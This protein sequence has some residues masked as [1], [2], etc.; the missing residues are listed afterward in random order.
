[1]DSKVFAPSVK[2]LFILDEDG[3]RIFAQYW[4]GDCKITGTVKAQKEF[5]KRASKKTVSMANMADADAISFESYVL[6]FKR[7]GDNTTLYVLGDPDEN[8]LMLVSVLTAME[9]SV[10]SLLRGSLDANS[11][12]R[13]LSHVCLCADEIV[14]DGLVMETDWML[15]AGRASMAQ[16]IKEIPIHDQTLQQFADIAKTK[17][18]NVFR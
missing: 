13:G 15:I 3:K 6:V 2:G 7:L 17:L 4:T 18:A 14:M 12:L 16:S 9:E 11:L 10:S 8:E 1:M 5:E